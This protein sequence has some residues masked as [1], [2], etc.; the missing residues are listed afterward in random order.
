M[1]PALVAW[2]LLLSVAVAL[3]GRWLEA[4]AR[5]TAGTFAAGVTLIAALALVS[6]S[7]W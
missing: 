1:A 6:A 2:A 4:R 3:W 7:S 5:R